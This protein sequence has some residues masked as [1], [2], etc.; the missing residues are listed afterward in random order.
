MNRGKYRKRICQQHLNI[1]QS[2]LHHRLNSLQMK[3]FNIYYL[4]SCA[5]QKKEIILKIFDI[6]EKKGMCHNSDFIIYIFTDFLFFVKNFS[7][8][9]VMFCIGNKN[10]IK[11]TFHMHQ[12]QTFITVKAVW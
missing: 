9:Q 2:S 1:V 3:L 11:K 7:R 5:N 12:V 8:H 6:F 10:N 4:I